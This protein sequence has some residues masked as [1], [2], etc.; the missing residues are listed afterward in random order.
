MREETAYIAA[1]G[2]ASA[3]VRAA[4]G[5]ATS[6]ADQR[7]AAIVRARA[8]RWCTR[9]GYRNTACGISPFDDDAS[10]V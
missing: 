8:M 5:E 7:I 4:A 1:D 2:I 6:R 9:Q 10:T 3:G